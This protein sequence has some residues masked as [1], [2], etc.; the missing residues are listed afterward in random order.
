[1][2]ILFVCIAGEEIEQ[3]GEEIEQVGSKIDVAARCLWLIDP[4]KNGMRCMEHLYSRNYP[5]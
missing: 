2:P 5:H 1:V 3:A 4:R